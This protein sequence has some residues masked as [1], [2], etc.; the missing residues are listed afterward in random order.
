M[1]AQEAR[2]R[3]L[4]RKYSDYV[5][6]KIIREIEHSVDCGCMHLQYFTDGA[7]ALS[8]ETRDEVIEKLKYYGY[9]ININGLSLSIHW[10]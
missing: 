7:T 4:T 6:D 5:F 2:G 1:K 8:P 3:A 10:G 9:Q